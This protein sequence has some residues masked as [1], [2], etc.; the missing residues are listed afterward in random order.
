MP[1][2]RNFETEKIKIIEVDDWDHVV[3]WYILIIQYFT[4]HIIAV[5]K[6]FIFL[7]NATKSFDMCADK[8]SLGGQSHKIGSPDNWSIS[9]VAC[10]F[11]SIMGLVCLC[12]IYTLK[13]M[14]G[15][16]EAQGYLEDNNVSF[17]NITIN[18][19]WNILV[20]RQTLPD[21]CTN[22]ISIVRWWWEHGS[23]RRIL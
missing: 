5:R 1:S 16:L 12:D 22:K 10:R 18:L 20:R 23:N 8:T 9:R 3:Q 2:G 15:E 19:T 21:T 14:L 4:N 13:D 6:Y 11:L 17:L 7:N